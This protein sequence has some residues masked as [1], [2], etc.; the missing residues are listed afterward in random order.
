MLY[1]RGVGLAKD[2]EYPQTPPFSQATR[3]ISL[4]HT[5]STGHYQFPPLFQPKRK[6][7]D[8]KKIGKPHR[9]EKVNEGKKKQEKS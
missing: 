8:I 7:G 2:V 3:K 4:F 5:P 1:V 9:E 6:N